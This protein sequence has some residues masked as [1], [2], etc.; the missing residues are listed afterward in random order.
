MGVGDTFHPTPVGV[1]FGGR[2]RRRATT[3]AD[4]FF[5]GAGPDREPV[6][7]VRRVHDRLPAQ[8]QEHPGQ[9][10]PLPRRAAGARV[11]AA[12]HGHPGRARATGRRVRRARRAA[13]RPS[14]SRR[15]P[16][17]CSP[18]SRSCSPPPR[19][20]PSGC[21]TGCKDEGHLPRLSD[22]LGDLTRTNSESILGAIAPDTDGRLQPGRRDHLVVPPRRAHPH[23]AGPLRQG[24]QLDVAAADGADRRRR[25]RGRAGG[26]GCAR[27][28]ASGRG[29]RDL[30][31]LRH[32][33]ERTDHRAGHADAATTRSRRSR[34]DAGSA[35][36]AD[37]AAGPRRAEPDLDPG[38]PTR[39]S[40][41]WPRS[42]A[43]PPAAS[44]GEP[45]DTPLTAHFLGGCA[46]GDSAETG[47]IDPYHRVYG[48]P[49][50]HVVDGSAVSAN[51]GVN[52]SLTITAQAERAM[53]LLAQ[54]GRGRPP[55]AARGGVRAG[56]RRSPPLAR[57]CRRA[58]RRAAAA[59]RRRH[60]IV[61][62]ARPVAARS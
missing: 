49:G 15:R 55:A 42:W 32:W 3:V 35:V 27:C 62:S 4:P 8:R 1:F 43:A 13:P 24:Q 46:I 40:A 56:S 30:Y 51:L 38:R 59:D 10:L 5:G 33:S 19:S 48:Y 18:P 17:G 25:R 47:V 60:L 29:V 37:L 20:A 36:G 23:R 34:S 22:R 31:D 21:C 6:H 45:F 2:A 39:R 7:R 11:H 16:P 61:S 41:G 50:L 9:E 54:Q 44:I 12:H 57:P 52:P 26:P 58:P 14:S 53:A 28:G